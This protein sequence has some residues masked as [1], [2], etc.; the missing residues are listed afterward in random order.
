VPDPRRTEDCATITVHNID[1]FRAG[2]DINSGDL[3]YDIWRVFDFSE[4][5]CGKS[6]LLVPLSNLISIKNELTDERYIAGTKPDPRLTALNHMR[7]A[8]LG[9][10]KGRGPLQV[11]KLPN[12]LFE[13]LDGNATAQV[14]MMAGWREAPVEIID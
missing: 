2:L 13:I 1:N 9:C 7:K 8:G 10:A 11:R 3:P 6:P 4:F 5:Q 14:L 12:G